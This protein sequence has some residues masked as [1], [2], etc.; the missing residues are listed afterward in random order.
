MSIHNLLQSA[1]AAQNAVSGDNSCEASQVSRDFYELIPNDIKAYFRPPRGVEDEDGKYVGSIVQMA[2]GGLGRL[3][4][5]ALEIFT[6]SMLELLMSMDERTEEEKAKNPLVIVID[7][8]EVKWDVRR[9]SSV[10][11]KGKWK[12]I[13]DYSIYFDCTQKEMRAALKTEDTEVDDEGRTTRKT[14]PPPPPAE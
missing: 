4:G 12:S 13:P 6:S 14:P 10:Q 7:G 11:E 1:I 3:H 5:P 8:K 2:K 9:Y